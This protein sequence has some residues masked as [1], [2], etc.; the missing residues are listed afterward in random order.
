MST[1]ILHLA[2]IPNQLI[3][4]NKTSQVKHHGYDDYYY[5]YYYNVPVENPYASLGAA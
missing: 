4:M 2:V 3:P 1:V 5:D